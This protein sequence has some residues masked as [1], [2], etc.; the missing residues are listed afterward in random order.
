MS[1]ETLVRE[2]AQAVGGTLETEGDFYHLTAPVVGED[3][4]EVDETHR[5]TV[6][7]YAE[8]DEG[9]F[10]MVYAEAGP[11]SETVDLAYILRELGDAAFTRVYIGETDDEG[12]ES[13]AA[14]AGLGREGLTA[15]F[16]AEVVQEVV[17]VTDFV[18]DVIAGAAA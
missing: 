5:Q 12:H 8:G 16:L 4:E 9:E 13:L 2:V 17:N 7:I 14:E 10:V 3:D 11:Y 1:I 6:T 15:A 18:E